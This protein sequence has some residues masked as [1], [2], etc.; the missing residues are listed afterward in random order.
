MRVLIVDDQKINLIL[1]ESMMKT[2]DYS[3]A[4]Y[5]LDSRKAIELIESNKFDLLIT[6]Y[7]MPSISGIELIKAAKDKNPRVYSV[8]VS[9]EYREEFALA[10][11]FLIKPFRKSDFDLVINN[12]LN[13]KSD[14][15]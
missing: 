1:I 2:I 5:E 7:Y 3:E 14:Y 12:F 9:A 15:M 11:D 4:I 10:N 6:D 13:K 8:I